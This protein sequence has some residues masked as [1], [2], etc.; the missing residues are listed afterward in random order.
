[1]YFKITLLFVMVGWR[2]PMAMAQQAI[3][4]YIDSGLHSNV[5]LQQR[6]VSLQKAI[7]ALKVAK[8]MYLPSVN[9]LADYLTAEGGRSI[10]FPIGDMLNPVYSTLNQLT[11]TNVFPQIDNETINFLPR[12]FYDAR[13]RTSLPV[14]NTDIGHSQRVHEQQV[15]LQEYE[16]DTYKRELVK[17]IKVAYFGYLNAKQAEEIYQSALELAIE[18]KRVNQKLLENGKGLPAYVLRSNSEV[19]QAEAQLTQA[20]LQARNAQLYFNS[21]L[22][23]SGNMEIDTVYDSGRALLEASSLLHDAGTIASREELQSLRTAIGIQETVLKM[24]R[25]YQVPK[26]NA[27]L[28]L[29]S[30]SEGFY[31]NNQTRY[32][33]AGLQMEIPLFNGNRSKLKIQQSQLDVQHARLQLT[34]ATEQLQLANSVAHH[35]L[36]SAWQTYR[37][38]VEQLDAIQAYQRLISKGYEAGSNTYIETVDARNQYTMA[39]M[40]SLINKYQVLAAAAVLERE[41]ASYSFIK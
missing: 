37:S 39:R 3:D 35:D 10:P 9:F 33:M 6:N 34:Q 18:G 30:Q 38:S 8:S 13:I 16:V 14:L 24:N 5:L 40:A 21:L 36:Q 12:H 7:S 41:N 28:D 4:H 31:F 26:L 11:Q 20:N 22:N 32:Y 29:G 27:F 15:R 17:A 19:A 23:R 1:M 2:A 25:Q